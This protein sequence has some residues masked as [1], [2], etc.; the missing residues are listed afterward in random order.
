MV[1]SIRVQKFTQ[2][3][4]CRL[5]TMTAPSDEQAGVLVR[6]LYKSHGSKLAQE[7]DF[8][9]SLREAASVPNTLHWDACTPLEDLPR[10]WRPAHKAGQYIL[11]ITGGM[12]SCLIAEAIDPDAP[13]EHSTPVRVHPYPLSLPLGRTL[14]LGSLTFGVE[15]SNQHSQTDL[16]ITRDPGTGPAG[17][18]LN[19]N[20]RLGSPITPV[21][22][23]D[24][25]HAL[26]QE[27]IA[28]GDL[29][30]SAH[31]SNKTGEAKWPSELC[32]HVLKS[33][34]QVRE[35]T[36]ITRAVAIQA[37]M[38]FS[39]NSE[40]QL[41]ACLA[42]P[43]RPWPLESSDDLVWSVFLNL[44]YQNV[45]DAMK[46]WVEDAMQRALSARWPDGWYEIIGPAQSS[47]LGV[48]SQLPKTKTCV[49]GPF[50]SHERMQAISVLAQ[51]H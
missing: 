21:Q 18:P 34:E 40:N 13:L 16:V 31:H 8:T 44:S 10:V 41:V 30:S 51:S 39:N 28:W 4:A 38:E 25:L 50:T 7:L 3:A 14:A 1:E 24:I 33:K 9:V 45:T 15:A 26:D 11:I 43:Q 37:Y 12:G 29:F 46:S 22:N 48:Q 36:E 19:L 27:I 49:T 20:P 2:P 47:R 17:T 35:L 5:L 42:A 32:R 23:E 6:D